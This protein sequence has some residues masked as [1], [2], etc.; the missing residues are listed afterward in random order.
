MRSYL[1]SILGMRY[2]YIL[3]ITIICVKGSSS[4]VGRSKILCIKLLAYN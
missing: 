3:T 2:S 1:Y 4:L